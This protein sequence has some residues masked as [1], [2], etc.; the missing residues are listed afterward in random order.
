MKYEVLFRK[1]YIDIPYFIL[2]FET[3][4]YLNSIQYLFNVPLPALEFS[5]MDWVIA[6]FSDVCQPS[7]SPDKHGS[8]SLV[9]TVRKAFDKGTSTDSDSGI[10]GSSNVL[11]QQQDAR[12]DRKE[13]CL[14]KVSE[15]IIGPALHE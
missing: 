4:P 9:P 12:A 13:N 3:E 1:I 8:I 15:G 14:Q 11:L 10:C 5:T 2:Q 6:S 7:L